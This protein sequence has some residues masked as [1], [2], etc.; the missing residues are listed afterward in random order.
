MSE[1]TFAQYSADNVVN[2]K[3]D[4][5]NPVAGDGK[6]DDSKSI[7]AILASAAQSCKAVFFPAGVYYVGSTVHIP[8][9]SRLIG[10]AW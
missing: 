6:T 2:V 4:S 1:P 9:N 8:A 10:E 7:N 5:T 3:A